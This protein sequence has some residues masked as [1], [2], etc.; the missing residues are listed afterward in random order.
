MELAFCN[1]VLYGPFLECF[2]FLL[3]LKI[4]KSLVPLKKYNVADF[5]SKF[6]SSV[7]CKISIWTESKPSGKQKYVKVVA[8][9]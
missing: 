6:G 3:V 1:W 8:Y 4:A 2:S 7:P 5:K 9:M